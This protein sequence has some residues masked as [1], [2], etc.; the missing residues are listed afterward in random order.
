[1]MSTRN[2]FKEAQKK[3]GIEKTDRSTD[4]IQA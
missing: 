3:Y 4:L 2:F 1:M